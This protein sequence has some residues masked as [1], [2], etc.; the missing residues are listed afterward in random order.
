MIH[1]YYSFDVSESHYDSLFI[2]TCFPSVV[3]SV[4]RIYA[5][6]LAQMARTDCQLLHVWEHR[7]L[8]REQ[9]LQF[10]ICSQYFVYCVRV[11]AFVSVPTASIHRNGFFFANQLNSEAINTYRI[12]IFW[13]SDN[14][15]RQIFNKYN[16]ERLQISK[17]L[18]YG[19]FV[20]YY[21]EFS[22]NFTP[23]WKR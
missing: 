12:H 4:D 14:S 18:V 16:T 5:W 20:N 7:F 8:L 1:H 22:I 6:I 15:H 17:R 9:Y 13:P 10:N 23:G 19:R 21:H 2:D 11:C 3:N